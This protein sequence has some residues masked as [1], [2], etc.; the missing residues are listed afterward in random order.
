[1]S[2]MTCYYKSEYVGFETSFTMIIPQ[3]KHIRC[4]ASPC[5]E[6][7][8]FCRNM[9]LLILLHDEAE[10]QNEWMHMTSLCRY[11]GEYGV[12]VAMPNCNRSFYSDYKVR[13]NASGKNETD[14]R[15]LQKFT[16]LMY[17]SYITKEL[18]PYIRKMFPVTSENSRTWIGGKGMGGFG[19]LKLGLNHPDLF[20]ALFSISGLADLQWGMDYLGEKKEQFEAIFGGLN[21]PEGSKEDFAGIVK[22]LTYE[23]RLP[24]IYMTINK[25]HIYEASNHIFLERIRDHKKGVTIREEEP[26]VTWEYLDQ[27][28]AD[29][30]EWLTSKVRAL[31]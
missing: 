13:D 31:S 16:E 15:A 17:E 11:A 6:K 14:I 27:V 29:I 21:V 12:A 19:A 9:P 30:L 3:K 5:M 10:G 7:R 22:Q 28:T 4:A 25:G 24:H 26:E 8:S 23:K 1:M 18:V 2:V 20:G